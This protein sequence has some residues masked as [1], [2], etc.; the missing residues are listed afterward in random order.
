MSQSSTSNSALF[1]ILLVNF[2]GTLGFSVVL[3]F[4][5]VLVLKFGGNQVIYGIMGATYSLFQ[6]I[7][8]PVLGQWSDKHGRRKIL[9][10][11]QA[12]T[13]IAWVI[14]MIALLVPNF[15]LSDVD[16]DLLG[17][18]TITLPLLLLFC[19]RALDGLTGGNVSVANAYLADISTDK[20]RKANF[21]KM[22]VSANLGFIVGPAMAGLLGS[23]FMGDMLPILI[24]MLISMTA[25]FV[26]AFNLEECIPEKYPKT[27]LAIKNRKVH[28]LEHKECYPVEQKRE[29][30]IWEVLKIK[31]LKSI[32][33]LYFLIFLAFNF[34]YVAFPVHA[35]KTLEWSIF[36]L[37]VFLSIMSG[38]M[39]VVQGPVLS[40]LSNRVSERLLITVG[41]LLLAL[42]FYFFTSSVSLNLYL[43]LFFF[44]L[45]NGIMWPSF[46][47][48]LSKVAGPENQ[49]KVQGFA[50]SMGSIASIIGLLAGGI[51]Y[52]LLKEHTFF[53]PSALMIAIFILCL[54]LLSRNRIVASEKAISE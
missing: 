41:N 12:G 10:L 29:M 9:L 24:A 5:V 33:V 31:H 17:T 39:V 2:I 1:P 37:G 30:S 52:G 48:V 51:L 4:L 27:S 16:S 49:G 23:T 40:F 26:I 14:F 3:P 36:K 34:F 47:A 15:T 22:S 32:L 8:A 42:S 19:A 6:L 28:G 25:I 53:I 50:S 7:G 46:M 18:F 13:F 35:V 44:A 21:G 54:L 43:G 11:S 20:D 38:L 45:G